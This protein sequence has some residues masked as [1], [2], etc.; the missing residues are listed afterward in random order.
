MITTE[1]ISIVLQLATVIGVIFAV[2]LYFRTPQEKDEVF[3]AVLDEKFKN[4]SE[5]LDLLKN[6]DLHELKGLMDRHIMNQ[7]ISEREVSDKLARIDT[8]L[9][10]LNKK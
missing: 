1:N 3:K 8:K 6:N 4:L 7:G 2:Y 5:K 10:M 9:E